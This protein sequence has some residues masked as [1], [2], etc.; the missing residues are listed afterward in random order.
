MER[1]GEPD[2]FFY[3][4]RLIGGEAPEEG[5]SEWR[6]FSSE[7]VDRLIELVGMDRFLAGVDETRVWPETVLGSLLAF[8]SREGWADFADRQN[9]PFESAHEYRSRYLTNLLGGLLG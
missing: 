8:V 9:L 2:R 5:D 7:R 3:L 4:S 1:A 6:C